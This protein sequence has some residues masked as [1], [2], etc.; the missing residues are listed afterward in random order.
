MQVAFQIEEMRCRHQSD[1][2]NGQKQLSIIMRHGQRAAHKAQPHH[3]HNKWRSA[4]M[5]KRAPTNSDRSN[6]QCDYQTIFMNF[7][8]KQELAAQT[9]ARDQNNAG[10]AMQQA[11]A[12]DKQAKPVKPRPNRRLLISH[13]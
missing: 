7:W 6:D 10:Q 3:G 8:R 13:N 5:I 2:D 11:Q 4:A 12:R 1:A 9:Q